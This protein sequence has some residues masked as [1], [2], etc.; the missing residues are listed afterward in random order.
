MKPP[1]SGQK[2]DLER[3]VQYFKLHYPDYTIIKDIGSGINFKRKGFKTLLELGMQGKIKSIVVTHKDRLCRFGFE[4][5]ETV[6]KQSSNG[7]ILVLNQSQT[8]PREELC[9]DIISILT[10]FSSRLY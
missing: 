7:Q 9:N 4:L 5:F 8:S 2:D 3:Q 1:S 10:V 6:I